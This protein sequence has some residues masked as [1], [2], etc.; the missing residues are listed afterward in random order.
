MTSR[1]TPNCITRPP[2]SR[3]RS[4]PGRSARTPRTNRPPCSCTARSPGGRTLIAAH[5][6]QCQR[7]SLQRERDV[8][9]GAIAQVVHRRPGTMGNTTSAAVSI[10]I[11]SSSSSSCATRCSLV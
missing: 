9:E 8:Y 1:D 2:R 6:R 5:S 3:P 10:L 7:C 4:R 11:V